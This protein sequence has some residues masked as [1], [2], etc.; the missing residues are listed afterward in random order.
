MVNKLL[1]SGHRYTVLLPCILRNWQILHWTCF[2]KW[3]PTLMLSCRLSVLNPPLM[4]SWL[5]ELTICMLSIKTYELNHLTWRVLPSTMLKIPQNIPTPIT[6]FLQKLTQL[7]FHNNG[8]KLLPLSIEIPLQG[9]DCFHHPFDSTGF[10][11]PYPIPSRDNSQKQRNDHRWMLSQPPKW[12]KRSNIKQEV[13]IIYDLLP[14]KIS[15]IK[16]PL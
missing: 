7:P 14:P 11:N 1:S 10:P 4:F 12:H 9:Y 16:E 3:Y 5:W 6:S 8:Y 15:L 13:R 2:S